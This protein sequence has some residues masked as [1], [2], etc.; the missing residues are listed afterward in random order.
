MGF[1]RGQLSTVS[2]HFGAFGKSR[3]IPFFFCRCGRLAPKCPCRDSNPRGFGLPAPQGARQPSK[4]QNRRNLSCRI[5]PESGFFRDTI[6]FDAL[7]I[8]RGLG[9]TCPTHPAAPS[10]PQPIH[11]LCAPGSSP[12]VFSP[13]LPAPIRAALQL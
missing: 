9:G 7:S 2:D 4:T 6:F 3:K 8:P 5:F 1:G 10:R 12:C 11:R 13:V